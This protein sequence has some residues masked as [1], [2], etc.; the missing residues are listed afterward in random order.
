VSA[1]PASVVV[2]TRDRSDVLE[3]CLASI[4]RLDPPATETVVVDNSAGD[5]DVEDLTR[6]FQAKY[7]VS[8]EGGLSRARNVGARA[9]SS[10]IIAY[11]DDDATVDPSWLDRHVARLADPSI[12]ATTGRVRPRRGS[13]EVTWGHEGDLGADP[14]VIDGFSDYWFERANFG[15]VGIGTN[16]AF[17]RSLFDDWGFRESIGFGTRLPSSDEHYAFFDLI[18]AGHRIAYVPEAVVHHRGNA[19]AEDES[20]RRRIARNGSAYV[21][22]LLVEEPAHRR[23]T[24]RYARDTLLGRPRPWLRVGTG[25]PESMS[26]FQ[27]LASAAVGPWIYVTSR[28]RGGRP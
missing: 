8:A 2:C 9:A 27:A 17:R 13:P 7:A 12:S 25:A 16:M 3:E 21:C 4:A 24:F 1:R 15:G 26:R 22:M 20:R 10:S 6:R 14:F 18:R 23:R 5:R 11:V 19:A 28:L